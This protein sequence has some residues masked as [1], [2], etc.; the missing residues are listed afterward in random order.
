MFHQKY[1]NFDSFTVAAAPKQSFPIA[2][3]KTIQSGQR[4]IGGLPKSIVWDPTGRFVAVMFKF[5]TSIAVFATSI[6]RDV[7]NISPNFTV[8]GDDQDEFPTFIC[9]REIYEKYD[10]VVLTIG[11]STG[12]VQYFPLH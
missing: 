8:S 1:N 10:D 12:R 9:F 2:D 6:N 7:L 4:V 5:S 3:F 11:W